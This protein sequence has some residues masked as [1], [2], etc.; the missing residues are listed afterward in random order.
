M[1]NSHNNFQSIIPALQ[2]LFR[3]STGE[4]W[5]MVMFECAKILCKVDE[6]ND[7]SWSCPQKWVSYLYF[8]SFIFFCFFLLLNLFVAVIMDNF[9][10]LTRDS[11][12]LGPHHLDEFVGNWSEFDP[13]AT[14]R[15]PHSFLYKMLCSL[16]PPVGFGKKCPKHF[17]YKRLI[18][19]NMPVDEDGAV[20]FHTT[21][22]ALIRTS[23]N[24]FCKGNMYENDKELRR[25]IRLIWPKA[26]DKNLDKSM[27]KTNS[28][29]G[30]QMTVGKIYC[31][32]LMVMKY[33]NKVGHSSGKE[34]SIKEE[35]QSVFERINSLLPSSFRKRTERKRENKQNK[36][37]KRTKTFAD[38]ECRSRGESRS[39][40]SNVRIRCLSV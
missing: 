38:G 31:V 28:G 24:V 22:L 3:S 20:S 36:D 1:L 15:I 16:T 14:G 21:L 27:P 13:Q 25:V 8:S 19:M 34:P 17:A 11:S 2:V 23:L 37:I 39:R 33:R 12:I 26:A 5:N 6:S 7:I 40:R 9:E 32:K 4:S 30:V 35:P 18:K 10:Y 29:N